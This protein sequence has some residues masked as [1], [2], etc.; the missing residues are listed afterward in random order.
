MLMEVSTFVFTDTQIL[1]YVADVDI[2]TG[3]IYRE[4]TSE[5]FYQEVEAMNFRESLYKVF[6]RKKIGRAHV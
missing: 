2:S 5:C 3:L 4:E 1:M 6:N